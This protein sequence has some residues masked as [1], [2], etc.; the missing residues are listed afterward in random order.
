MVANEKY[1]LQARS[2]AQTFFVMVD[3]FG[4]ELDGKF[5]TLDQLVDNY[6]IAMCDQANYKIRKVTIQDH[7]IENLVNLGDLKN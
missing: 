2:E 6:N 4:K 5:E 7:L 3:T 1:Q